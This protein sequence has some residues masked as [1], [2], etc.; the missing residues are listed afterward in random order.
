MY[1]DQT[2]LVVSPTDLTKFLACP[3]LTS[4]DLAVVH[5]NRN[6]PNTEPDEA[7]ELLFRK[8]LEHEYRYLAQLEAGGPVTN[9]DQT[10]L[11]QAAIDTEAAM[12]DGARVIY[13]A[14]FLHDGRR[15][16]ADFLLRTNSPSELG[17]W[18]YDIADTKLARRLKVPALLQMAEYGQHLV[19][20]QGIAPTWLTVV[21][22]DGV[23]HSYRYADVESYYRRVAQRFGMF[24]TERPS[25]VA[26][27]V[28]HCTQCRWI[29]TCAGSW[30]RQDHLSL[31]AFMRTD[32]RQAL[33][34]VG[35][36][37]V[38]QLG[39]SE[40][41]NLPHTIGRS[42]R[43]RLVRQA[44]L[45][46]QER[47]NGEP[48]Y[49]LLEPETG[50]GLLRLPEP[51]R[52]DLYLDFEGDPYVEPSGREYLAG[53][54]TRDG[55]FEAMWAHSFEDESLLT[56]RLVDLIIER[57]HAHPNMHV[58]HY[59]PYEKSALQRLT[60]RHG[61]REAELDTLLRAEVLVDLYAVVRQGLRI[62][63]ESYSIKKMEAFY[64]GHVRGAT[65]GGGGTSGSS[66]SRSTT[67]GGGSTTNTGD[68]EVADAMSSVV[69]YERWLAE[70]S[71]TDQDG[72]LEQIENYNHDDVRSTLALH[73]WLEDRRSELANRSATPLPRPAGGASKDEAGPGDEERA[74]LA[75]AERL[76]DA[77]LELFAGLVGWHRREARPAWWEVF[78]LTDLDDEELIEDGSAIGGLSEPM[79]VRDVAQS[80]IYRYE[81]PPQDTKVRTGE[82]PLDVDTHTAVG[83]VEDMSA[84]LG[85]IEIRI[86]KR[87]GLQRPRGIGPTGP[88]ADTVQRQAIAELAHSALDGETSLG[89]RLLNRQVPP[90][91][92]IAA[93]EDPAQA[94]VRLGLELRGEVLAVQGPPGTGKS[95]AAAALIRALLDAGLRVGV[96][97]LSHQVIGS[98]LAKV[99]RPALQKCDESAKGDSPLI[100]CAADNSDVAA[101]L[102]SGEHRLVGGTAWVWSRPEFKASVDVLLIDEAGQFSLANALAVSRSAESMVLL[103]DPQQLSQPSQAEHP[104]GAGIS[105][106]EHLL[107]GHDT[108]PAQRGVFLDTTWRMHPSIT[109]FVSK[110]SYESRLLSAATLERQTILSPRRWSG[111]GLRWVP[112]DHVGNESASSQEA[113]VVAGIV[114]DLLGGEWANSAGLTQP[115]TS[116]QILV[117]AP[118]NAHVG[119]LRQE[120]ADEVRVGTVDKFQGREAAIV[121]YTLASSS[122]EDAPR[123]ID[124][125]YDIHRLNV[126]V[127]RARAMTILVG[128]P[129]LL[130]AEVHNPH[131]LRLVNALCRYVEMSA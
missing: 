8:G 14:T 120:I 42:S 77:G 18:S 70:G 91:L 4:L 33:E 97:A 112:V 27:P 48:V 6:R 26:Q 58:Y 56:Q 115:I 47:R 101:A 28:A 126:A 15:G 73:D 62:S 114:R 34:A 110:T 82:R 121:I 87:R 63:K 45:Q 99:D 25:T 38:A 74:E 78:R 41:E 10:V 53:V 102:E 85:W 90:S 35:I 84:E 129:R 7:L 72:T 39:E 94:V 61:V 125:L 124:F 130:D 79:A 60:A 75:L 68:R 64:W 108:M 49:E 80:R 69:A 88:L 127:S 128:S 50:L 16:H 5:G 13:Q 89:L 1:L 95:T 98:L 24:V 103:G 104:F 117:V 46:L 76:V 3:H 106:L 31:V 119:R 44:A 65:S 93:G 131:Q 113:T 9:I 57:W 37:T 32:H 29:A 116:E 67:N 123:G 55:G 100:E 109:D 20:L 86:S 12:V 59:A 54:G 66:T 19:R 92:P 83:L 30:R 36:S 96:T 107:E 22:G 21:A 40:P 81:F 111:S 122:A 2:E 23:Q 71:A 118:Y 52:G 11:K 17:P 105:A 51:D 43:E